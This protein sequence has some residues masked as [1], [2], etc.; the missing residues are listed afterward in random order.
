LS[1]YS[2]AKTMLSMPFIMNETDKRN[3]NVNIATAGLTKTMKERIIAKRPDSKTSALSPLANCLTDAPIATLTI[4]KIMVPKASMK[5]NVP[6]PSR[7][8]R[9]TIIPIAIPSNP[10]STSR[11]LWPLLNLLREIPRASLD[12]PTN[13]NEKDSKNTRVRSAIPGTANTKIE[14][15]IATRPKITRS[16]LDHVGVVTDF[17][18]I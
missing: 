10:A 17:F 15:A 2:N 12:S 6:I 14:A 11:T 9:K 3:I 18:S 7:G 4:P 1:D 8:N 13:S 16:A 5:T